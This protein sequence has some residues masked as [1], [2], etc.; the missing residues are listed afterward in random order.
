MCHKILSGKATLVVTVVVMAVSLAGPVS[1]LNYF[2]TGAI[3]TNAADPGNWVNDGGAAMVGTLPSN[4]DTIRIGSTVDWVVKDMDVLPVLTSEWVSRAGDASAGWW[5]IMG[6]TGID[7]QNSLTIGDG[8]YIEWSHNDCTLRN[9][10]T[11]RVTGRRT[12]G[13]PSMVIAPRFRIGNN[14]DS[15]PDA[16]GSLIVEKN[17]YLRFDPAVSRKGSGGWQIYMGSA[18]KALIEIRDNGILELAPTETVTPRFVFASADPAA[19]KIVISGKGQLLLAGDPAAIATVAD[20]DTSLQSLI[21]TGL[22]ASAN[23]DEPLVLSGTNPTVVKLAGQR[24]SNPKPADGELNTDRSVVLSWDPGTTAGQVDVYFGTDAATVGDATRAAPLGVL[25]SQGQVEACYPPAGMLTLDYGQTYF[26]RVDEAAVKLGQTLLKGKVWSF[27]VEPYAIPI[28]GEGVIAAA[29]G[30]SPDQGPD[31]TIDRSGLDP[32]DCHSTVLTDMWLSDATKPAWIEYAFDQTYK[33]R[34]MLAWNYNGEELNTM[35]G[36]KDVAIEYSADGIGSTLLAGVPPF[37]QALGT[38]GYASNTTVAFGDVAAKKVR[39]TAQSNWSDGLFDLYGLSEVRFV[40]V[41]VAARMPNPESGTTDVSLDAS[42][43]WRVGRE[44]DKHTVYLSA[45]PQAVA[46]G[47]APA[48][49]ITQ[50]SYSPPSLVLDTTYF[51]RVDEVNDNKAPAVWPGPVWTFTTVDRVVVDGF[52]SY[53]DQCNRVYYVW[54]GGTGNSANA[55]CGVSAYGGNGTGSV[56]G[57]DSAPYAERAVVHSGLQAMP[58]A[59]NGLSEATR[60][61]AAAQDWTAG[62]ITTLVVFFQGDPANTPGELY[63]KINGVKVPYTGDAGR[64]AT[65]AWTQW[66]I[67]LSSVAGLGSVQSLTI[68]VS[69][70]QGMLTIDDLCLYRMPPAV[71]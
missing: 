58:L 42:L 66:D 24:A 17:G 53:D 47:T 21:D 18:T 20:A 37:E 11:L 15:V 60:T 50:G 57:N 26:W 31:R 54:K 40:H 48:V 59:Y 23:E 51:W 32:N 70:G 16:T 41:P 38:P 28:P 25:K 10:T 29:S 43:T 35:L 67:G 34:Q 62:G 14:G 36:L 7:S 68:G 22:I 49:T 3:G 9:G 1:A 55:E 56:V 46:D 19:N 64:L 13:G 61:F 5:L 27:T 12:G 30:Q 2:W 69:S 6:T 33:I 45:D 63:V 52:E 4:D 44:A 39:I 8:A 71:P 65:A